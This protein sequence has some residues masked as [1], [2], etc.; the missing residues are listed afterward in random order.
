M[1]L[2]VCVVYSREKEIAFEVKTTG[3]FGD[4][5]IATISQLLFSS[6]LP[7]HNKTKTIKTTKTIDENDPSS[8]SRC[9]ASISHTKDCNVRE[10]Q[11][12]E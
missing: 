3:W 11:E 7:S 10:F 5:S 6:A 4:L 12:K 1:F 9:S 2:S 8:S